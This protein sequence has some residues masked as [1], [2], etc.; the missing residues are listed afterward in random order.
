MALK[1]PGIDRIINYWE[2][3]GGEPPEDF[4]PDD[5]TIVNADWVMKMLDKI[6]NG[7]Y[8]TKSFNVVQSVAELPEDAEQGQTAYVI[9]ADYKDSF[10]IYNGLTWFNPIKTLFDT[11]QDNLPTLQNGKILSNDGTNCIWEDRG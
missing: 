5:P 4:N 7:D 1:I 11:K 3:V 8:A 9:G 6:V 10:F 2:Y